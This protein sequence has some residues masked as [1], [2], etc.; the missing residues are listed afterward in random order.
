MTCVCV[1]FAGKGGHNGGVT[2]TSTPPPAPTPAGRFGIRRTLLRPE[3]STSSDRVTYVELFFDLIFVFALTQLSRYLYENQ[4]WEGALESAM[5]VLALWW[6]WVYTTWVTNW[7]DPAK[8]P[9]R[10]VVLGLSLVGFVVSV[11]IYESFGDRGIVFALAYSVLQLGRTAFMVLAVARHDAELRRTFVRILIWLALSS[12]FWIVGA[13]LP[14]QYRLPLWLIALAIEY[15][16]AGVGFR[17]PGLGASGIDQWNLS[18][19]HIAERSALF[20]IIALG[21]SLLVTGF[22]FVAKESSAASILGMLLAFGAT[23]AMWWLYF[24][25]SERAGAKA[26]A[27]A[28]EPGRIARLAYTYVHA[29]IIAGIVLTSVADKEVL[30]HPHTE[31]TL[32]TAVVLVGG[33][34]LYVLGML[35]FRLVVAR[36]LLV[37]Y[38]VGIGA[39]L[40]AFGAAF[41]LTPLQLGSVTT[42]VLVLVA[43]WETVVRVRRGTDDK[44]AG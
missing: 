24:D 21:E 43:G 27:A 37:S 7:L 3:D 29:V 35:L 14:L 2:R 20:V 17:V 31:M 8:L 12:V 28:A 30:T 19:P 1:C 32:S 25:H 13:L 5:L 10:G 40:V 4:S 23:V 16:S 33:P 15:L 22:A 38:L 26:I 34:A 9:V 42:G 39:L 18:G 11:S 36:E 41:E 6:V 44:K